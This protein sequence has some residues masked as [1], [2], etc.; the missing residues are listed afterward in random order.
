[1]KVYRGYYSWLYF[2]SYHYAGILSF[3]NQIKIM[4][5]QSTLLEE[6]GITF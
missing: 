5:K 3:K 1:M 2:L 6:G 4:E